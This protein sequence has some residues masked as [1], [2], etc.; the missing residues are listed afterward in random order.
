MVHGL[1]LLEGARPIGDADGPLW[2]GGVRA[3]A[4][5]VDKG[6]LRRS[7]FKFFYKSC[8]WLPGQLEQQRRDGMWEHVELSEGLLL[9]QEG[10]RSMWSDV[11]V[12]LRRS[13][14]EA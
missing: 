6:E 1:H 12:L 14:R 2:L 9:G 3:A 8:E 10:H 13:E 4:S 5:M 11:R 7:K